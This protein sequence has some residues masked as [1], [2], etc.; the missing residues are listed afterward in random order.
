MKNL[1]FRNIREATR[2][3]LIGGHKADTGEITAV[4]SDS[5]KVR[6]GC[7]FLCIPG[8]HVDGHDF[9]VQAVED[10]AAG[11]MAERIIPELDA[12]CIIVDSILEA[13]QRLAEYY[14]KSLEIK[15]VGITGSVG[16]TGT[17]ELI[18]AVL[19][20]RYKVVKTQGNLNN[21]W[22]VPF[23]IFEIEEDDEA[24][25]IEMG[26]SGFGEMDELSYMVKPDIV[27]ITNI[28][29]SHLEFLK[30]PDGILK[31]KSEIFNHM[32]PEGH[33][34]LNGDDDM[35]IG[36]KP[37]SG[38]RPEYF[39]LNREC[40][41]SAERIVEKG[42]DGV[43]FDVVIRDGGGKISFHVNLPIPGRHMV[44]NALAAVQ[45]GIDMGVPLMDIKEALSRAQGVEGRN[46]II[47]MDGLTLID[48][49]Y[50]A[51]PVSMMAAVDLLKS[52]KGRKVAIL[53]DM[54]ELGDDSDKY[55]FQVGRYAGE[56][57]ADLIICV[58]QNSEKMFMGAR[59]ASDKSVEY[60]KSLEDAIEMVPAFLRKGDTVLLKASN[61]MNFKQL[62][63]VLQERAN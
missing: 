63:G 28:G 34:I 56:S 30:N 13:T 53:G 54:F 40:D 32:N 1:T 29:R 52:V 10:G 55:H 19:K 45:V 14:R 59:L 49:C 15:V 46:R 38:K 35:L 36:L 37:P 2:G 39:G 41:V 7:L 27:V 20:R 48:D 21:Q 22:G 18:A 26:I 9:A 60:F 24:A 17:K 42:L 12:P 51:S 31:A 58:G 50:N 5:R 3:K 16:K 4:I 11:V 44:Y 8:E 23:T 57:G 47:R 62:L 25:V 61:G 33:I 6:P 43:E